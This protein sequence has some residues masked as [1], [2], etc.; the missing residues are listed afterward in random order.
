MRNF[1]MT[2]FAL[3]TA[4]A[5]SFGAS[6]S[7][8]DDKSGKKAD[9]KDTKVTTTTTTTTT[10][11]APAPSMEL[12]DPTPELLAAAKAM[13]GTWSCKG[14]MSDM[15][16]TSMNA[17]GTMKWAL[18]L[19]KMWIKGSLSINKMKGMKRG[20]KATFYRA[21]TGTNWVHLGIDNMGGWGK[22]TSTGPDAEGK[23]TFEGESSMGAMTM[24]MKDY[25]QK[26]AKKNQQHLWGEFSMD[27]KQWMPAYDMTCTK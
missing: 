27:G 9:P 3:F 17:K 26:G 16:G 5:L 12:P 21:Y 22:S 10:T 6:A 25:E 14:T 4:L 18:D 2:T 19:D 11:T 13:K 7:A 1:T 15:N 23:T 8:G 20:F 24:K